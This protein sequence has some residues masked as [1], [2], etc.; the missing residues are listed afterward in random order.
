MSD[1]DVKVGKE[2]SCSRS[3]W[4]ESS[5]LGMYGF[6]KSMSSRRFVL[7]G[8][9][10]LALVSSRPATCKCKTGNSKSSLM[11]SVSVPSRR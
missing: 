11:Y 7:S 8:V 5:K 2:A 3:I 1:R 9:T 4:V 10:I 6:A